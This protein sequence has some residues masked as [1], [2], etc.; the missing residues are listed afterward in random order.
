[1]GVLGEHGGAPDVVMKWPHVS[2]VRE[3]SMPERATSW[4]CS[5]SAAALAKLYGIPVAR[6]GLLRTMWKPDNGLL[7]DQQIRSKTSLLYAIGE[8]LRAYQKSIKTPEDRER[9]CSRARKRYAEPAISPHLLALGSVHD[10]RE[11]ID[12]ADRSGVDRSCRT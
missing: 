6:N 9:V 4:G 3:G 2:M 8:G 12:G 7:D 11:K 5:G 1:M 10:G